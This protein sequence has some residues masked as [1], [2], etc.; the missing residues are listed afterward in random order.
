[1]ISKQKIIS[2][3]DSDELRLILSHACDLYVKADF[4]GKSFFTKFLTPADSRE[5][6]IRFPK[7]G[8]SVTFYGGYDGA[9]RVIAVFGEVYDKSEY[10]VS[11]LNV[12]QKGGKELSHR[13]YLGTVLSLGLKREMVGDIIVRD[14]GA[15]IFCLAE[16]ADFIAD[17]LI[18]IGAS[19]VETTIIDNIDDVKV[20]RSYE[21]HNATVSSL[22][23]DC[24]V[25]AASG[26]SRSAAAALIDRSQV[27]VNHK[28][29]NSVSLGIKDGDVVTVRGVGKFLI[30]TDERLT[31]KGRI[32]IDVLKYV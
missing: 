22:R 30:K 29:A 4:S 15:Y 12:R 9:E 26:K 17:N 3:S 25:S 2:S 8:I 19:G 16:I 31:R 1:M 23:L 11:V 32:Y 18:K 6:D 21:R 27:S 14:D 5:I 10:P 13:D 20:E 28:E 24:V 7:S